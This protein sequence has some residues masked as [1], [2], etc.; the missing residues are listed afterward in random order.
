MTEALLIEFFFVVKPFLV[1]VS[2]PS[3]DVLMVEARMAKVAEALDDGVEWCGIGD[4]LI[5]LLTDG[6]REAGDFAVGT[7]S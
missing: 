6:E 1:A 3:G 2:F 4:P 5:D 7:S